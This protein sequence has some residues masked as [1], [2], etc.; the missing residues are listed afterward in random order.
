MWPLIKHAT[1]ELRH[2]AETHSKTSGYNGEMLLGGINGEAGINIYALIYTKSL[3]YEDLLYSTGNSTR[4][5]VIP[6]MGK[7]S[8]QEW[9][10]IT[11]T[12][13][14]VYKATVCLSQED[15]GSICPLKHVHQC[16]FLWFPEEMLLGLFRWELFHS[17]NTCIIIST[18][19]FSVFY[20]FA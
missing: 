16:C 19:F 18:F 7:E 20:F 15:P 4:Y 13:R 17:R 8:E 1:K 5:S 11:H 14:Y 10:Y 3:R 12:H 6:C 2:Q 9:T